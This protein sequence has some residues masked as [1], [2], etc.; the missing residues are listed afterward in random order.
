M[1]KIISVLAAC[2]IAAS[3]LGNTAV[4][5]ENMQTLAAAEEAQPWYLYTTTVTSVLSTSGTTGTC[6]SS[7]KGLSSVTKIEGTQYLE[8][9]TLWWWDTV[10]EWSSSSSNN[11]L[12]M[13]NSKSGLDSGT[14]RVRTVFTVYS[15]SSSE[16]VE[17]ISSEVTI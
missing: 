11:A 14:Y 17:K 12:H 5:A 3:Q 8:K 16:E 13:N 1:K 7:A 10:E 2:I 15:G 9:K 4:Y 6:T